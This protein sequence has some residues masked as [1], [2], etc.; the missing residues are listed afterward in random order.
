MYLPKIREIREALTSFFTKPYTTKYPKEDYTP[1]PEFRGF[2]KYNSDYCV[3][4]GTCAQVC[5][6]GA[7]TMTDDKE[8]KRRKFVINYASCIHCGQC[9]EHCIIERGI[10]L[11][12]QYSFATFNPHDEKLFEILEKEL[13]ICEICNEVISTKN[14]LDFIRNRIGAKSYAHPNI[15]LRLQSDFAEL[16]ESRPKS[17]IRREDQFKLV[18]SKC[19]QKIVVED[20][21]YNF[22]R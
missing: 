18:C 12:N 4:C 13:L 20:E 1:V 9:E 14:H 2:P 7:I 21:F 5:P 6:P 10:K 22:N 8:N 17:R 19:R 11:T 3:G 15:L 16:G